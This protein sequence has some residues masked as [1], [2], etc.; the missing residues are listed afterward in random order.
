MC[1]PAMSKLPKQ[2]FYVPA[3][4]GPVER[5]LGIAGN[6]F[7]PKRCCLTDTVIEN[8]MFIKCSSYIFDL[9]QFSQI[10]IEKSI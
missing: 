9:H 5:L 2:Y 10:S 3:S 1:L 8:F 6:I 4:S 7:C